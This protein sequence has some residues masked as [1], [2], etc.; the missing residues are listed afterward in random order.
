MKISEDAPLTSVAGLLHCDG[1]INL[2]VVC[3]NCGTMVGVVTKTDIVRQISA[4]HGNVCTAT[5]AEVMT[6]DVTYCRPGDTLEEVL[7]NMR[8]HG[9][10]H[11]PIVDEDSKPLG[12]INERDALFALLED[13]AHELES[14]E[15]KESLLRDYA[16]LP[17]AA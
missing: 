11:V 8:K 12:V 7:S 13:T 5:V 14:A 16:R 2:A 6:K 3:N 9:F 10:L 15:Y 17:A 4:C 1:H